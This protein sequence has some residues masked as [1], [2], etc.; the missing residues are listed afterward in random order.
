MVVSSFCS[1]WQSQ[2][3]RWQKYVGSKDCYGDNV[4]NHGKN[5][6]LILMTAIIR[7]EAM[8]T[9]KLTIVMIVIEPDCLGFVSCHLWKDLSSLNIWSTHTDQRNPLGTNGQIQ[10][11]TQRNPLVTNEQIQFW[12]SSSKS[13][14]R[15]PLRKLIYN[16]NWYQ[17]GSSVFNGTT[18]IIQH[19]TLAPRWFILI[20]L[21]GRSSN[22]RE[23]KWCGC[24]VS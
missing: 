20:N 5:F 9:I 22:L 2:K 12:S 23:T 6:E 8:V 4:D 24:L 1:W 10:W 3:W 11:C 14:K 21:L 15:F 16:C 13:S 17:I 19:S 7:I 18:H